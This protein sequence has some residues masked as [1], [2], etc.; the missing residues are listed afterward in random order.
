M[1]S[2]LIKGCVAGAA[3]VALAA[4]STTFAAWSDW[5]TL[6]GSDDR[7]PGT[8][9]RLDS[10]GSINN[11]GGRA[12][13]RRVPHDFD[14]MRREPPSSTACTNAALRDAGC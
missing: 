8:S 1:N 13:A 14:F 12:R 4:G 9:D 5:D 11:V 3:V 6:T 10:T 7:A 2:K